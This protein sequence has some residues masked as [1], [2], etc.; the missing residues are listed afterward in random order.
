[1]SK[2]TH[3]LTELRPLGAWCGVAAFIIGLQPLHQ[4]RG[5]ES[6]LNDTHLLE[7]SLGSVR[8]DQAGDMRRGG[9]ELADGTP[10]SFD[11]WYRPRLKELNLVFLSELTPAFG[12]IWGMSSGESGEKYRINPGLRFGFVLQRPVG[13]GGVISLQLTSLLG[14]RFRE[15]PCQADFGAIGG[16]SVAVNCRLAASTLP[17][18]KTLDYLVSMSGSDEARVTL[19]YDVSF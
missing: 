14:G 7:V 19:R 15:R 13:E 17:P 3:H 1:M 18:A 11:D 9:Y 2:T 6:F 8:S 5:F 4:A 16:A 10:V 12:L